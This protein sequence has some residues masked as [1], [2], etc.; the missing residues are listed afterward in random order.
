MVDTKAQPIPQPRYAPNLIP[1][2]SAT[3]GPVGNAPSP[4][5]RFLQGR[6][7]SAGADR[8]FRWAMIGC[9]L[10]IFAIVILIVYE[11]VLRSQLTL[12]KFG[13]GFFFHSGWNP[14]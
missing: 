4:I 11:L 12:R 9:A 7:A 14:V 8:V 13:P 10:S 2:P 6:G 1:A 3:P 5:R